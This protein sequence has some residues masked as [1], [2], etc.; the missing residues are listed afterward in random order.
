[1]EKCYRYTA[2]EWEA[3]ID[4]AVEQFNNSTFADRD[5]FDGCAVC[6]NKRK[7]AHRYGKG[8]ESYRRIADCACMDMIRRQEAMK[9]SGMGKL[10]MKY[11]FENFLAHHQPPPDKNINSS[12]SGCFIKLLVKSEFADMA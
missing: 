4:K 10:L 8:Q 6:R 5:E 2:E 12:L 9:R 11:G 1:M 3:L 7:V